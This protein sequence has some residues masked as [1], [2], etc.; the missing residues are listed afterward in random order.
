VPRTLKAVSCIRH[1]LQ[2]ENAD[3]VFGNMPMGHL[4]GGLA[5]LGMRTKRVWFQ[6]G[7]PA[8][9]DVVTWLAV[10]LPAERVYVNSQTSLRAQSRFAN[11]VKRVQLLYY[12]LDCSLFNPSNRATPVFKQKL[13]IPKDAPVV[14]MVARLQRWKGQH[15]FLEA[16]AKVICCCPNVHFLVIGDSLF[17][18][19]P[20][21]KT[22]LKSLIEQLGLS[23]YVT[24]TGFCNDVPTLLKEVD[25]VVHPPIAPEPFGLAVAEALLM[26]KPVIA[27]DQGGPA[28]IITD[29]DTG[30]LVLPGNAKAL[31]EKILLLLNNEDLCQN[32]GEKGRAMVLQR[33]TMERMI[34]EL[35]ESYLEI[36]QPT[37]S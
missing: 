32:M 11:R 19:E 12:G 35:E 21:Y 33:F 36:L 5:A 2:Q 14:A 16:A 29:G 37:N 17:G 18:L 25:I 27:S 30:V 10:L 26:G 7:I 20:D 3:L 22:E 28:E 9:D 1:I 6:H 15:I 13:G 23:R 34:E 8:L 24:F 31:A 4:Y